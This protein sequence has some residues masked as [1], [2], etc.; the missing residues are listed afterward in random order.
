MQINK[1]F[2]PFA[3]LYA[4]VFVLLALIYYPTEVR[5]TNYFVNLGYYIDILGNALLAG[6]PTI[7]VSA[8]TGRNAASARKGKLKGI[9]S[10]Y[11]R[12]C[13]RMINW[14]FKPIDG[15]SH[16][17]DAYRWTKYKFPEENIHQGPTLV[18]AIGLPAIAIVCLLLRP[19]I[20]VIARTA[21]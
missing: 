10:K 7:T 17:Q 3:V 5:Y 2:Y 20:S 12:G 19:I 18:F 9:A 11:W 16:C 8:R 13:E 14:A 6:N 21:E 1:G 15:P 4:L